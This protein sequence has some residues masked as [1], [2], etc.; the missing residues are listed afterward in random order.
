MKNNSINNDCHNQ[1]TS[2]S[3]STESF[4]D[5]LMGTTVNEIVEFFESIE[6]SDEIAD[7]L[8]NLDRKIESL[9]LSFRIKYKYPMAALCLVKDD[10]LKVTHISEG[11]GYKAS[12]V[13]FYPMQSE[14]WRMMIKNRPIV[15]LS[16]ESLNLSG[17]ES[18]KDILAGYHNVA[19]VQIQVK[20]ALSM[21]LYIAM[22]SNGEIDFK[23]ITDIIYDTIS[24]G[25]M[26]E[27]KSF[28]EMANKRII[29]L[30]NI[31]SFYIDGVMIIDN[32]C[33]VQYCS[34]FMLSV[35]AKTKDEFVKGKANI[36]SFIHVDDII[37]FQRLLRTGSRFENLRLVLPSGTPIWVRVYAMPIKEIG[38]E[39]SGW[40]LYIYNMVDVM[41]RM[42]VA[43]VLL[44]SFGVTTITCT[45]DGLINNYSPHARQLL[46][47][48]VF[49]K[50]IQEYF[51]DEP[52]ISYGISRISTD[53]GF[54]V[55][56]RRTKKMNVLGFMHMT[57]LSRNI[58]FTLSESEQMLPQM[59]MGD[60]FHVVCNKNFKIEYVSL[61]ACGILGLK[62]IELIF[63]SYGGYMSH[64]TLLVFH[65]NAI[66]CLK[67]GAMK[68]FPIIIVDG[69]QN[70]QQVQV[71]MFLLDTG[72][73]ACSFRLEKKINELKNKS[74]GTL[75]DNVRIWI[76]M[77]GQTQIYWA[78]RIGI[79]PSMLS[80][81]LTGKKKASKK[82]IKS[83]EAL[84]NGIIDSDMYILGRKDPETG[85]L[86][87]RYL[88]AKQ[89]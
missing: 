62:P 4:K 53:K 8:Q 34:P 27:L 16:S 12:E 66:D 65:S 42:E 52:L 70:I 2:I 6:T 79:H 7:I 46:G 50:N 69:K 49:L 20:P 74:V 26:F 58:I 89:E 59:D 75:S 54:I 10:D 82:V 43:E 63:V 1:V 30:F 47:D 81:I 36:S 71:V 28:I 22:F 23:A 68:D 48:V 83:I 55:P 5:V 76:E 29:H 15:L 9:L 57:P 87:T 64:D 60:S 78:E 32:D 44:E 25:Y 11:N 18:P 13:L 35:W 19:M 33:C 72:H 31:I 21:K 3:S 14:E 84:S 61:G 86:V 45:E 77:S 40:L 51:P 38:E 73:L 17:M 85:T 56:T 24:L 41:S 88:N 39:V 37:K 67:S 80:M